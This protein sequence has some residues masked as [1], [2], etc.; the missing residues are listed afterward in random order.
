MYRH[1]Y[2]ALAALLALLSSG[3]YSAHLSR[4][5]RGA[6]AFS[7]TAS[8]Q[9]KANGETL[10]ADVLA[11]YQQLP[12]ADQW[13]AVLY[14]QQN[15]AKIETFVQQSLDKE[16]ED[17]R[18]SGN[19]SQLYATLGRWPQRNH[20]HT[21][22]DTQ[23]FQRQKAVL[24]QWIADYPDS[25]IPWLIRG[26]LQRNYAWEHRSSR[27]AND[28]KF[29]R[30]LQ[31]SQTDLEQSTV[32]NPSDPNSWNQLLLVAKG[33]SL[34][35]NQMD[36]Y[37]Q[38]GLVA[39]LHHLGL[40]TS[41][42]STLYPQWGGSWD[43]VITFARTSRDHALAE[44]KPRLGITLLVAVRELEKKHHGNHVPREVITWSEIQEVYQRILAKYP[45][46]LRMRYDYADEAH[47]KQHY[48]ETLQQFEIIGDR[49]TT[50]LS[51]TPQEAFH[52]VRAS[53]YYRLAYETYGQERPEFPQGNPQPT[54][55]LTKMSEPLPLPSAELWPQA[56]AYLLRATI[57]S[58]GNLDVAPVV[59]DE[60]QT[61]TVQ[62]TGMK[63]N[64]LSQ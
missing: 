59:N 58:K 20:H 52:R 19:L 61:L 11:R 53:T 5:K 47:R 17:E 46:D 24:D 34:S 9:T 39:S 36:H 49:W 31:Q 1:R 42:L 21:S 48:A 41:R 45:D 26:S 4:W 6:N 50:G 8:A 62:P 44:D 15:F 60:Q 27:Q 40:R 32:L 51:W 64:S 56:Q 43:R 63:A 22:A 55:S 37:Y 10:S 35:Q 33:L 38:Q 18:I 23:A 30:Y 29:R 13:F 25:H 57:S 12:D 14:Q 16:H 7:T 28:L 2:L 3:C 54:N